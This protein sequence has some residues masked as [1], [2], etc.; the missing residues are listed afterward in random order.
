M[1][2]RTA[3]HRHYLAKVELWLSSQPPLPSA[4]TVGSFL[5]IST[6]SLRTFSSEIPPSQR[7]GSASAAGYCNAHVWERRTWQEGGAERWQRWPGTGLADMLHMV[8]SE[9][10]VYLPPADITPPGQLTN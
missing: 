8:L 3:D 1:G 5:L 7:N 6:H 10:A 4:D 9:V 2:C